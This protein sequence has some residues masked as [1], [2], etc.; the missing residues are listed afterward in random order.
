MVYNALF[1]FSAA[2][3]SINGDWASRIEFE[4]ESRTYYSKAIRTLQKKVTSIGDRQQRNKTPNIV[5]ILYTIFLLAAYGVSETT[6]FSNLLVLSN[7]EKCRHVRI[8]PTRFDSWRGSW[9][10]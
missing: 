1:A 7:T 8:M 3:A 6:E 2:D 9:K 5:P 4:I 10:I